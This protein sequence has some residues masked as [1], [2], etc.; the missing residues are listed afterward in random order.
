MIQNGSTIKYMYQYKL[1]TLLDHI[2]G[3]YAENTIRAY[4]ID[5]SDFIAYCDGITTSPWPAE[6]DTVATYLLDHLNRDLK[7]STIQ[8]RYNTISAIHRLSHITDPTKHPEVRLAMRKIKRTLGVRP[9]QAAPINHTLLER[10]LAVCGNDQRSLRDRALL[11]TAY[12]SMCRRSELVAVTVSD[13]QYD[14][15]DNAMLHIRRSKTDQLG[16]GQR[17]PLTTRT[18]AAIDRWLESAEIVDGCIFRGINNKG[19]LLDG[20]NSGQVNRI[21]K[22]LAKWAGLNDEEVLGIRGHSFRVGA[23]QDLALAGATV[24]QLLAKGRWSKID[25]MYRYIQS[26]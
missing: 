24:P 15:R 11:L 7:V 14:L 8:R 16:T 21:Y 2:E 25:T 23:A 9:E 6:P 5:M 3:A 22:R 26:L 1:Q 13:I 4:R 20:I 17:V 10:M 12:D 19:E 18:V